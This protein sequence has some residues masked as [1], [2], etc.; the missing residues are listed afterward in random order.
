TDPDVSVY[1]NSLV[2][3][4]V[5]YHPR[6]PSGAELSV[7]TEDDDFEYVT[8]MN[9][10]AVALDMSNIR[11]T[12]G[13]DFDFA[14]SSVTSL[15][16]GERAV[17]VKNVAAFNARYAANL[18][19]IRVAGAWQSSDSLSNSGEQIKLSFGAGTTVRDFTYDDEAPWPVEADGAGYS[20]V[21]VAPWTIPN[22][23]LPGSWR[24]SLGI[25]GTPGRY[26]GT[27]FSDWKAS[28][29]GI[30]DTGD[31]DNDGLNNLLEYTLLGNPASASQA[32]L[33]AA[34]VQ[35]FSTPGGDLPFLTLTV[36]VARGADDAAL[37]PERSTDLSGWD[38]SAAA[39]VLESAVPDGSG[40]TTIKWRSAQPWDAGV[41]EYLRLRVQLR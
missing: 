37:I 21:L 3:S 31:G 8:V 7:S 17:V 35:T 26:D 33:P 5:M 20:L 6:M 16:P 12:K 9:A 24:L 39:V 27:R 40:G 11:F 34:S 10:G 41:R 32:Q 15:A 30:T 25:D 18:G 13:I 4:E 29:G 22:H 38:S 2:V 1:L 14:G 36:K 28:H 19:S 23:A